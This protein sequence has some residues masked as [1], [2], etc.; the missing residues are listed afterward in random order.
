M[1]NFALNKALNHFNVNEDEFMEIYNKYI[2]HQ[3]TIEEHY[4]KEKV[5]PEIEKWLS[6]HE[7][8]SIIMKLKDTA[9]Y[10]HGGWCED[11]NE[12]NVSIYG[13]KIYYE[14]S[15]TYDWGEDRVY[16]EEHEVEFGNVSKLIFE[17]SYGDFVKELIINN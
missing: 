5:M 16:L 13:E 11:C 1:D 8:N 3:I 7:D 12:I 2:Y 6:K 4:A 14:P 17:D 10:S 15:L 9:C